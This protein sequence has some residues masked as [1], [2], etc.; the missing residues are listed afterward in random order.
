MEEFINTALIRQ[1]REESGETQDAVAEATE[2]DPRQL[3]RYETVK[4]PVRYLPAQSRD[5][6]LAL[7]RHYDVPLNNLIVTSEGNAPPLPAPPGCGY[8][9]EDYVERVKEETPA[10]NRLSQA[11]APVALQGPGRSGKSTLLG[12]LL[13]QA[14]LPGKTN[15]ARAAIVRIHIP[16]PAACPSLPDLLRTVGRDVLQHLQPQGAAERLAMAWSGPGTDATRLKSVMEEHVLSQAPRVFLA[17]ENTGALSGLPFGPEFFAMLR[18]WV[19]DESEP[20]SRLRLLVTVDTEPSLLERLEH[21][22]FFAL[23]NPIQV[24]DLSPAQVARMA[25]LHGLR[26]R[27]RDKEDEETL[28]ELRRLVGG[29]PYLTRCAMY[30]SRL[31]QDSL[32][33][34]LADRHFVALVYGR[35][36]RRLTSLV[37]RDDA[38][39]RALSGLLRDPGYPLD[40]HDPHG[41]LYSMG[42]VVP[43]SH[44]Q[45]G[46]HR[47]RCKLYEDHFRGE[48]CR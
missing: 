1:L 15:G 29:H 23:A 35:H 8:R 10:R 21:S 31:R 48:L 46:G 25:G 3:G 36:L 39:S 28:G 5:N 22:L 13:E 26:T 16:P 14:A 7:A 11:G 20:W 45:K 33:R 9:A 12:R 41:R 4:R 6:L 24:D 2:M 38:L 47:I 27:T 43:D 18:G 44:G 34:L 30:E 17:I 37:Q 40:R 42:L 19:E 32:G